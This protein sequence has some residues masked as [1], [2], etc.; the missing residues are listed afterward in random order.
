MANELTLV[1]LPKPFEREFEVI[2]WN[3]IQS[4]IRLE[5]RPAVVLIGDEPGTAEI[6]AEVGA[7]HIR[8][9]ARSRFGTPL[10]GD[11]FGRAEE[12]GQTASLAYVN[13]DIVLLSDFT[14]AL[15]RVRRHRE[16]IP[17]GRT[18]VGHRPVREDGLHGEVGARAPSGCRSPAAGRTPS[19]GIDYFVYQAWDVG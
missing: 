17:D 9:V 1:A 16:P 13:A 2:Q 18:S 5:P 14:S 12:A 4:W 10:V 11:V 3:A 6:A 8:D 15:K 19:T 7:L